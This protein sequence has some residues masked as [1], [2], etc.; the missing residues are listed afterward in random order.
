MQG[1][2]LKALEVESLNAKNRER[3]VPSSRIARFA[4]F[5]QLGVGLIMGAA[6]EVSKRTLGFS[7]V[8]LLEILFFEID[9]S[10]FFSFGNQ[11]ILACR[12]VGRYVYCFCIQKS[13]HYGSKC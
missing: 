4:Q 10:P 3:K 6:A 9:F 12:L 1:Y 11:I 8:N 13:F 7:K 2:Q 5:G